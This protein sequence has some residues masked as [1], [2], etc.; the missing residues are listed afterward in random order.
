MEAPPL[1]ADN[2]MRMDRADPGTVITGQSPMP[3]K[4]CL[5]LA[6]GVSS[7]EAQA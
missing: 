2:Y 3:F 6:S 7:M 1:R 4:H 5:F